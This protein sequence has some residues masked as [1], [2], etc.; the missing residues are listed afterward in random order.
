MSLR[1]T[2]STASRRAR[3]A[4]TR[5]SLVKA[6]DSKKMQELEVRG[7]HGERWKGIEHWQPYGYSFV[8][9]VPKNDEEAEVLIAHFGT[10]RSH[11]VIIG[12]AD[13][14]YR[15]KNLKEGESILY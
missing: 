7:H 2:L 5:G 8:P 11:P 15:P 13:R 6:D 14:R 3:L 12:V 1:E 9:I 10:N 4:F